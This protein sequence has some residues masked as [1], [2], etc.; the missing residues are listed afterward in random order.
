[1]RFSVQRQAILEA[2]QLVGSIISSRPMRPILGCVHILVDDPARV[3]LMS[4]DLE[5]TIRFDLPLQAGAELGEVVVPASRVA[6]ILREVSTEEVGFETDE[7]GKLRIK[8][9]RSS[10][11]L[12]GENPEEFPEMPEFD[13][14]QAFGLDREKLLLL[15]R[16]TLFAVAKEKSR[17]AF[18]GAKL[19]IEGDT[20][21]MVATDGKRLATKVVAID[22]SDNISAGPIVPAR[23]LQVFEKAMTDDDETVR[24]ALDERQ[25]MVKTTRAEISSRLV[26]GSFPNYTGVIPKE[27]SMSVRFRRDDLISAFRQAALLT[28]QETR[29]VRF[30]LEDG[31]ATLSAQ[32]LDAGDAKIELDAP[33]HKGEPFSISFNP[34]FF[35]EGLK[36]MDTDEVEIGLSRPNTPAKILGEEDL[37]YVVMPV[38][39][40]NV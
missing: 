18:N 22:N 10:F 36:V 6:S 30:S 13:G 14:D 28:S 21:R 11:N 25:I 15:I 20:A 1:M 35:T 8:S 33:D 4:S 9:G 31:R 32:A 5:I 37:V 26:D 40:R 23:A 7:T 19:I 16:K 24:I 2:F 39:M 38:T 3:R 29:S 12:L 17:F 34:D 27:T